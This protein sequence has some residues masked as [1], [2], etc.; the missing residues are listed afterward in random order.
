MRLDVKEIADN[1]DMIINGYVFIKENERV[2]VLNLNCV[3]HAVVIL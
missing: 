2:R 3:N 1:A